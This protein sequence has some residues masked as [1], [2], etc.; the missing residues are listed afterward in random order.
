MSGKIAN[1]GC[2]RS[3]WRIV[4]RIVSTLRPASLRQPTR[5]L[6]LAATGARQPA[7]PVDDLATLLVGQLA[8]S[9]TASDSLVIVLHE[10]VHAAAQKAHALAAV[11]HQPP[12]DETQLAPPRNGLRRHVELLG[13]L[14]DRQHLLADVVGASCRPSPTDPRRTAADRAAG[15]APKS[16][17]AAVDSG[18]ISR[19]A[20]AD[21][22][23]GI[24]LLPDR[25]R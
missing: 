23:V 24:R 4:E 22:L 17:S 19:D 2:C 11:K 13:Q 5:N 16:C 1:S 25:S 15:R 7:G 14:F 10:A 18:R 12:A 9:R 21:V 8:E 20:E 3:N 6:R